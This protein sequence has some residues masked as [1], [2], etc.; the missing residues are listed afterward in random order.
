MPIYEYVCDACRESFSLLQKVGCTEKESAC[1]QCGSNKVR[2]KMSSF[3]CCSG[4]GFSP[5]SPPAGF[6]GGG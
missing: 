6:S 5:S 3:S 4:S 1:P 2:R